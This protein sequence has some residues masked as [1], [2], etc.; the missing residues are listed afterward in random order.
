MPRYMKLFA[1]IIL[2]IISIK[3]FAQTT[4]T[5]A[6]YDYQCESLNPYE[7]DT[8]YFWY[9]SD[10]LYIRN[11]HRSFCSP[12]ELKASVK[13]ENDTIKIMVFNPTGIDCLAD[14]S[15]GYTI[16]LPLT[17][18]ETLNLKVFN[19]SFKVI[20][21]E[22]KTNIQNIIEEGK[23]WS[24]VNYP[25]E[26]L[27]VYTNFLKVGTDT[28][29]N[30]NTYH[31][32][33]FANDSFQTNWSLYKLIRQNQDKVFIKE[34]NGENEMLLYDFGLIVSDTFQTY[35]GN[36]LR[37]DSV[38]TVLDKKHIYLSGTLQFGNTVWIEDVGC[39]AGLLQSDGNIG[40]VGLVTNLAC[41]NLNDNKLY[42]DV[43]YPNCF[44]YTS[45]N[46]QITENV[47]L[48]QNSPNPYIENTL[49]KVNRKSQSI[50]SYLNIYSIQGCLIKRIKILNP[51]I[52]EIVIDK[53]DLP[54]GIYLYNLS[55]GENLSRTLKLVHN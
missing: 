50:E 16:K 6:V 34:I 26:T 5:I 54:K 9:N 36:K 24:I 2:V 31:K 1:F 25:S 35:S 28:I 22:L 49:I 48:G 46:N 23:I 21:S 39:T 43:R 11:I 55:E 40:Q 44:L 42:S 14:C 33:L 30:S 3:S 41:C 32:L 19:E 10:T 53:V 13:T 29:V 8:T 51:G 27:S 47:T 12:P 52:N 17:Q 37:V 38:K 45:I 4:D 18:F 20:K 15:F 7:I